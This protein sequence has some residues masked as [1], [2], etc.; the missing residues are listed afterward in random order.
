MAASPGPDAGGGD[1]AFSVLASAGWGFAFSVVIGIG[2]GL[3]LDR[4]LGTSPWL[5]FGGL[6]LGFASGVTNL[7]R[8]TNAVSRKR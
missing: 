1:R 2:G 8:A 4:W 7:I 3:L 5:L 6:A